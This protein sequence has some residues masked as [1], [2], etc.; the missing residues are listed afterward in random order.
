MICM[1]RAAYRA[2]KELKDV[3]DSGELVSDDTVV[4]I[5]KELCFLCFSPEMALDWT[6]RGTSAADKEELRKAKHTGWAK[7][8]VMV[9]FR[10]ALLL[11]PL[12]F[13]TAH[14]RWLMGPQVL[15]GFP[16]TKVQAQSLAAASKAAFF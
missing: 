8:S 9:N 7:L 10:R 13:A 12:V 11:L 6:D 14:P 4:D 16:R 1:F 3:M 15:D 2:K 5:V